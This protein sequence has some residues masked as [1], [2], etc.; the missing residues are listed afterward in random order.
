MMNI[1]HESWADFKAVAI[2][3]KGLP[4][5]S[6]LV[7]E[8]YEMFAC[9]GDI[10]HKYTMLYVESPVPDSEQEDWED[11]YKADSNQLTHPIS[12][13]MIPRVNA[14]PAI[15]PTMMCFCKDVAGE[16]S[17]ASPYVEW[18][19]SY[20]YVQMSGLDIEVNDAEKFDRVVFQVGYYV[21]E[22]WTTVSEYGGM[23]MILSYKHMKKEGNIKTNPIPQGLIL[24][25]KYIFSD[26]QTENTPD[27]SVTY[28]L[29]R[30]YA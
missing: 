6:Q 20:T 16:V 28:S 29:W 17:V 15:D 13:D 3:A 2:I 18:Q 21:G 24:R 27:V 19:N 7:G 22:D 30:P 5:Q 8:K 23:S 12:S 14:I 9:D 10:C 1:E 11:N 26:D 4:Y 25:I